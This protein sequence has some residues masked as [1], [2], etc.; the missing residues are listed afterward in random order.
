MHYNTGTKPPIENRA[1]SL[2]GGRRQEVGSELGRI[3]ITS[4]ISAMKL[5]R[6]LWV[7]S[8]S[9]QQFTSDI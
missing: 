3:Q 7:A 1:Y 8:A 4:T 6:F 2:V 9:R 5:C